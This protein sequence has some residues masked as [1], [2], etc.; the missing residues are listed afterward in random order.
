MLYWPPGGAL[1][2]NMQDRLT[3][4]AR[5]L[6]LR[7]RRAAR[8]DAAL[9]QEA[10]RDEALLPEAV[11]VVVI[12]AVASALGNLLN[13]FEDGPR[14][15][16]LLSE[17]VSML[18]NWAVWSGL[19][20]FVGTRFF[21]ATATPGQL[22]RALGFAMSP[23]ALNVLGFLPCL[24]GPIRFAVLFWIVAAGVIAV[25]EA[26]DCDNERALGIV[27]VSGGLMLALFFLQLVLLGPRGGVIRLL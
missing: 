15:L 8:L 16:G 20:Y 4:D 27:A 11:L 7:M 23:G 22:L 25:R 17:I 21:H 18:V 3:L 10:A 12:A 5:R 14:H 19:T 13:V 1:G 6:A 26:L 24:G 9:Y 2:D